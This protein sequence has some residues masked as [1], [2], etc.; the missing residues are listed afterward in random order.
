MTGRW[1]DLIWWKRHTERKKER[2][3]ERKQKSKTAR[4]T[5]GRQANSQTVRHTGTQKK[6][7]RKKVR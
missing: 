5:E 2:K 1:I 4:K 6:I 7:E 3:K